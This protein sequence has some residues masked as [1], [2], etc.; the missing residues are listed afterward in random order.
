MNYE[1]RDGQR[2]PASSLN[3]IREDLQAALQNTVRTTQDAADYLREHDNP[4]LSHY[5]AEIAEGV[6]S[7]AKKL[8]TKSVNEL[9]HDM[10]AVARRNP[11]LF[12]AGSLAIGLGL[13]RFAKASSRRLQSEYPR[14]EYGADYGAQDDSE[15]WF[16]R[17]AD[18]PWSDT[19]EDRHIVD[20]PYDS[21][22]NFASSASDN[23]ASSE[24]YASSA[25]D[26]P[27]SEIDAPP[28]ESEADYV[29]DDFAGTENPS[30]DEINSPDKYD[31][32][33]LSFE[34]DIAEFQRAR[35]PRSTASNSNDLLNGGKRYE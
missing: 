18:E 2:E 13:S 8:Q 15:A 24:S 5:V 6:G 11:A 7:F 34:D 14:S 35:S 16:D 25:S 27:A 28:M 17:W 33:E 26:S 31:V 20:E 3:N 10:E 32:N 30:L 23:F 21:S 4:D 29:A 19:L 12:I 9:I 1:H 22:E